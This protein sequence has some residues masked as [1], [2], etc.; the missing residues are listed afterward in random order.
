MQRNC[1]SCSLSDKANDKHYVV[2]ISSHNGAL[3]FVGILVT[4]TQTCLLPAFFRELQFV[5]L[6]GDKPQNCWSLLLFA[7]NVVKHCFLE[8]EAQIEP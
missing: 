6:F 7:A 5:A 3:V 4:S 8:K 1:Y 2:D